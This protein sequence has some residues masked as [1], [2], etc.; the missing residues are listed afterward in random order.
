MHLYQDQSL[1][2]MVGASIPDRLLHIIQ[3]IPGI[4]S[5]DVPLRLRGWL[6]V[7]QQQGQVYYRNGR[8]YP[9]QCS[10]EWSAA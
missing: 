7:L 2:E 4:Q 10:Q 3:T 6:R 9:A 8:W 5:V 1:A